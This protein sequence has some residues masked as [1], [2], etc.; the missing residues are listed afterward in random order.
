MQLINTITDEPRQSFQLYIDG[1]ETLYITLYYYITQ[2]SWF[3]D[4]T[5]SNY[6]CKGSRV[7][8]TYNSIRHLKN[9]LP[10]G[11]AF[12]TDSNAEPFNI[13]D[14]SSGRIKMYILDK[15]EV[16][17]IESDIFNV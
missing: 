10:F 3:Y 11:I 12:L 16:E 9:L 14:F 15:N 7:V 4:F 6:T 17:E 8:L 5:Y 13:N 2:R 1:G